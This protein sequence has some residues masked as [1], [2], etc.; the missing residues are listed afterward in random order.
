[1]HQVVALTLFLVGGLQIAAQNTWVQD[2]P[3][4]RYSGEFEIT[5]IY[6]GCSEAEGYPI[7]EQP[8]SIT[9]VDLVT[10][11]AT[12]HSKPQEGSW[13]FLPRVPTVMVSAETSENQTTIRFN[14][15]WLG[16]I[17]RQIQ[18]AESTAGIDIDVTDT[19]IAP[20]QTMG[21]VVFTPT[22]STPSGDSSYLIVVFKA[23]KVTMSLRVK[24]KNDIDIYVRPDIESGVLVYLRGN[25]LTFPPSTEE[26]FT[27]G[28][29]LR[30]DSDGSQSL[31]PLPTRGP[32]SGKGRKI[33][34]HSNKADRLLMTDENVSGALLVKASNGIVVDSILASKLFPGQSIKILSASGNIRETWMATHAQVDDKSAIILWSMPLVVEGSAEFFNQGDKA[35]KQMPLSP[36]D[37]LIP[38]ISSSATGNVLY[39][40]DRRDFVSVSERAS[41]VDNVSPLPAF[42]FIN[43]SAYGLEGTIKYQISATT[44][45]VIKQG[46]ALAYDG[47]CRIDVAELPAGVYAALLET[48]STVKFARFIVSR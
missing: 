17:T 2:G 43:V 38:F 12:P 11:A 47:T 31:M 30:Y 33:I 22:P 3:F 14:D 45:D 27:Y 39:S 18:V 32:G 35:S 41:V 28:G 16:S 4:K 37:I 5:S 34:W 24:A 26:Q 19:W 8:T 25:E 6:L 21:V 44:G 42:D 20:D 1:M 10:G 46:E 23:E 29:Y 9:Q 13:N 15:V 36:W 40:W 7:V 48:S